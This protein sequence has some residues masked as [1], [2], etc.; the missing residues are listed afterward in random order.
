[1]LIQTTSSD[2]FEQVY[3]VVRLIPP[4]RVTSYGA[5]AAFL[6]AKKSSRLVGYALTGIKRDRGDIP[7]HRVVNRAGLLT[8][9]IH[10]A[11]GEMEHLLQLE[12]VEVVDDKVKDFTRLFWNPITLWSD[13]LNIVNQEHNG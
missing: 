7:A 2:F 12:G 13:D 4:G 3:D 11:P 5:I 9:K 8:G 6:G 10:F 1:M